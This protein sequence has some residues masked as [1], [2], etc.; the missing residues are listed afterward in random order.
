MKLKA[1][2]REQFGKK[3]K[4][5]RSD[6]KIPA[7]VFGKNME[8]MPIVMDLLDFIEV[9][10]EA[11]ETSLIDLEAGDLKGKVIV[12]EVQFHPVTLKPIHVGFYKVDLSQKIRANVPVEIIG[13]EENELVKK[14]EGL[15]LTLLNEIEVEALPTDLPSN[16][17]IDISELNEIGDGVTAAELDYDREK[18]ELIDVVDEKLIVKMDWAEMEEIEEEEEELTEEELIG[19]IEITEEMEAELSEEELAA[20]REELAQQ[21]AE[22]ETEQDEDSS[23]EEKEDQ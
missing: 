1:Q 7:V 14:G 11:G 22:G 13:E 8:S 3:N 23:E 2:K 10:K 16:F 17:T 5:L 15:A 9:Y 6:R 21:A 18:V 19:Q 4:E 20:K 12:K